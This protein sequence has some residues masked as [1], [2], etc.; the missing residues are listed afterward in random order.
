[1]SQQYL[2]KISP[3][4]TENL[5]KLRQQEKVQFSIPEAVIPEHSGTHYQICTS[6]SS[7][8]IDCLPTL[9]HREDPMLYLLHI[10]AVIVVAIGFT[11]SSSS[12]YNHYSNKRKGKGDLIKKVP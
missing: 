5:L 1:M 9:G 10:D 3:I 6:F 12:G 4:F 11:S 8:E 2:L 7:K